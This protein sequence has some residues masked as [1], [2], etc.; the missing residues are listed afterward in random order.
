METL[1]YLY[2]YLQKDMDTQVDRSSQALLVKIAQSSANA[3]IQEQA[4]VALEAL[5][6][7]CSPGRVLNALLNTGLR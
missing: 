3:F 2:S 6:L 1:V 4:N 7:S 5:V